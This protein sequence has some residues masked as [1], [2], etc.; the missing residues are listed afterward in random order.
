MLVKPSDALVTHSREVDLSYLQL[1]GLRTG[2]D[3]VSNKLPSF[4]K[5]GIR[6][7]VYAWVAPYGEYDQDIDTLVSLGNYLVSRLFYWGDNIR[8]FEK[9]IR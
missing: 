7:Y 4:N 5:Y 6:E 9:T 2:M 1:V 3:I 8:I